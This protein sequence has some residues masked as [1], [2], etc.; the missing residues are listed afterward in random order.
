[1]DRPGKNR[2][3]TPALSSFEEEREKD[4]CA[5]VQGFNLRNAFP[6]IL[7]P[8]HRI[9]EGNRRGFSSKS[10]VILTRLGGRAARPPGD[11]LLRETWAS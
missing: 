6:G 1:M 10:V 2:L 3:L 5:V 11:D 9:E 8:V 7:T 4:R